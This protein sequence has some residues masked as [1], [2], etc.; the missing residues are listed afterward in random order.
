M[1]KVS[2]DCDPGLF[3][4]ERC[5]R[6]GDPTTWSSF[7]GR[8]FKESGL[9]ARATERSDTL[10]GQFLEGTVSP[11]VAGVFICVVS[12]TLVRVM[13]QLNVG[14]RSLVMVCARYWW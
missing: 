14:I 9:G 7:D 2:L 3:M 12:T 1:E 13:A 6:Y 4:V 8:L 10:M 11:S 5:W